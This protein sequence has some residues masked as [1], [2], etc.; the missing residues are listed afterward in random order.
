LALLVFR[1]QSQAVQVR[2]TDSL[3]VALLVTSLWIRCAFGSHSSDTVGVL[4]ANVGSAGHTTVPS[5]PTPLIAGAVVSTWLIVWL[6]LLV[7]RLQSQAVQVRVTDSLHVALLVTSLWIRCAFG[8]HP[9]D[10][11][12]RVNVYT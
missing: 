6:A 3:H 1:L 5:G 11:I 2:V 10:K 7:F 9:S 8:S 4:N 12:G